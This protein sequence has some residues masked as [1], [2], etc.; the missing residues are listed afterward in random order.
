MPISV[1]GYKPL[2]PDLPDYAGGPWFA[3]WV[4]RRSK[5]A[6]LHIYTSAMA[7][8]HLAEDYPDPVSII[9]HFGGIGAHAVLA[10]NIFRARSHLVQDIDEDAVEY[11]TSALDFAFVSRADAYGPFPP[12]QGSLQILDFPN[13]TI[14]KFMDKPVRRFMDGV[15]TGGAARAVL[16]TDIAGPRLHLVRETYERI[17]GKELPSY[18]DYLRASADYISSQY[19]DWMPRVTWYTRWS[20]ITVFTWGVRGPEYKIY[21]VAPKEGLVFV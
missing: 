14:R 9:E 20:A 1:M 13:F 12:A 17:L 16:V 4:S 2:L 19:T 8:E 11:M 21:R 3:N 10:H 7:M 5:D 15:F 6:S 18:P